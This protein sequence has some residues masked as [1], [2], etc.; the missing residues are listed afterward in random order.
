[1]LSEDLRRRLIE[2][3]P[4]W[5]RFRSRHLMPLSTGPDGTLGDELAT[6]SRLSVDAFTAMA[7]E[8]LLGVRSAEAP[9]DE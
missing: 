3:S 9:R 4:F 2:L 6:L 7:S 1:V 5:A 8:A